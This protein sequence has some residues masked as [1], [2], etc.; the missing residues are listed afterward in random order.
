MP[1]RRMMW[2]SLLPRV[3]RIAERPSA[4]IPANAWRPPQ[5]EPRPPRPECCRRCR[6][7]KPTGIDRPD[8]SWR[9]IWLSVVRAPIAPQETRSEMYCGVIGSRNSQPTG[10]PSPSTS[11]SRRRASL[12]TGVDVAGAV[13]VRIVD[14]ALPA[15]RRARLLEVHAHHDQQVGGQALGPRRS[16]APRT[17]GRRPGH[18]RCRGRRRP[19]AGRPHRQGSRGRRRGRRAG[20]PCARRPAAA[21]RTAPAGSAAAPAARSAGR[22]Q[23]LPTAS[24]RITV[25]IS[26][27]WVWTTIHWVRLS[28]ALN[29]CT[30]IR[31]PRE[32]KRCDH[33]THPPTFA[34]L[35]RYGAALGSLISAARAPGRAGGCLAERLAKSPVARVEGQRVGCLNVDHGAEVQVTSARVD[36]IVR[37]KLSRPGPA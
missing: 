29:D 1:P 17:P 18:E 25:I 2:Q 37:W 3:C 10:M 19:S 26:L 35:A 24:A 16:A 20:L 5:R 34:A 27:V 4:S 32:V 13:E 33:L 31:S 14:Q 21:R 22:G 23:R 7:L 28:S 8:P 12:Q 36:P 6:F 15:D 9:W 30:E 11:S